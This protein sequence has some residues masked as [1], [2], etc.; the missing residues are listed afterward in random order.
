[1]NKKIKKNGINL[2]AGRLL[3]TYVEEKGGD[4][5]DVAQIRKELI[6]TQDQHLMPIVNLSDADLIRLVELLQLDVIPTT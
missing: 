6:E 3:N 1:V 5:M 2:D 4:N